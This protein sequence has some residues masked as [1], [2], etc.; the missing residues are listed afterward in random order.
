MNLD[1]GRLNDLRDLLEVSDGEDAWKLEWKVDRTGMRRLETE[2]RERLGIA[3]GS[4]MISNNEVYLLA[5]LYFE[6]TNIWQS[7]GHDS[8]M[9]ESRWNRK[10]R[11]GFAMI[12]RLLLFCHLRS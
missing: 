2:E 11:H 3:I 4:G 1:W 5:G 6:F 10:A 9:K 8:W 12:H 7:L